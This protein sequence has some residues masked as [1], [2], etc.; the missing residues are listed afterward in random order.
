[1][2]G[3]S[4]LLDNLLEASRPEDIKKLVFELILIART[5]MDTVVKTAVS[6]VTANKFD[7]SKWS[8][9]ALSM[10]NILGS[11][12]PGVILKALVDCDEN[13]GAYL[14]NYGAFM[15][16][17]KQVG[18]AIEYY[19][20]AYGADYKAHGHEKASGFPAW[21]NLHR[22]A[23][24]L[25]TASTPSYSDPRKFFII[26]KEGTAKHLAE[27][28]HDE[29]E[30]TYHIN[31]FL[32]VRDIEEGLPPSTPEW[33]EQRDKHLKESQVFIFIV[34][35]GASKSKE[36][37]YELEKA[38]QNRKDIKAFIHED[39]WNA[40]TELV[41]IVNGKELNIKE[42]QVTKFSAEDDLLRKVIRST[43]LLPLKKRKNNVC[44]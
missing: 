33:K 41:F 9:L 11:K 16:F 30:N 18:Q 1:L 40:P 4:Q 25:K 8:T 43:I 7:G 13:N 27:H 20:R 28:I 37:S 23:S 34:T 42:P 5:D 32:N 22:I 15:E 29:L 39:I 26:Y 35:A 3:I 36:V 12:E 2:S 38:M 10:I 21:T 14:N 6:S 24:E 19:A 44:A 17:T 31:V